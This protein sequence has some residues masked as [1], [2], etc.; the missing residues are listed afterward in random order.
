MLT[1]N[2]IYQKKKE[3]KWQLKNLVSLL[4]SMYLCFICWSPRGGFHHLFLLPFQGNSSRVGWFL[5]SYV[6]LARIIDW[7]DGARM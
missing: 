2:R 7:A 1:L 6:Q 3:K 4:A 5:I